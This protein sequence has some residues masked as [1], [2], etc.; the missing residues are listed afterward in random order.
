MAVKFDYFD[1]FVKQAEV[2]LEEAKLLV[3]VVE[4]FTSS[5]GLEGV[6]ARAHEVEHRGDLLNHAV[7]NNIATDF[8]TPIERDDLLAIAQCLDEVTDNIE[9]VM[10]A[11]YMYDIRQM[12]P[13]AKEFSA[14]IQKSCEAL[15][16]AIREFK[17]YKKSVNL[18][19]QL[20]AVN[21]C[22]EEGDRLFFT[23]MR[24]LY[25]EDA[26]NPMRVLVWSRLFNSLEKCCDSCEHV[27]DVVATALLKNS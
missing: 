16:T 9:E 6:T 10:W 12:R 27:A 4:G 18:R 13:E 20:V 7:Y 21:D 5:E 19:P 11:F 23:A 3:E 17:N 14:I 26:D 1:T 22:E 25:V 24:R 2:C 15:N 8:I